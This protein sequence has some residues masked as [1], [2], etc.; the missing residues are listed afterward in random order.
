MAL[1]SH[2]IG[3]RSEGT[4]KPGE[5]HVL[6][7]LTP[8]VPEQKRKSIFLQ[9]GSPALA[10]TPGHELLVSC[11]VSKSKTGES[12]CSRDASH[13]ARPPW[14]AAAQRPLPPSLV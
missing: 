5:H 7:S 1:E 8:T 2:I 4:A 10:C 14:P 12:E 6:I 13:G 9:Q 3:G 11:R